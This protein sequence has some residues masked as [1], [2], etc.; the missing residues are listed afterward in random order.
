MEIQSRTPPYF[1][2]IFQ[3][4]TDQDDDML[5]AFG[6]HVHWGYWETAPANTCSAEE[7]AVAAEQLCGLIFDTAGI[8][9]G[10]RILDVGCGFGGAISSLNDRYSD[11]KMVGVNVDQRQL[12]RARQLVQPRSGNSIEFIQAVAEDI[13]MPD[14]GFDT[15]LAVESAFH[16]DRAKFLAEAGRVLNDNGR[17]TVSDFVISEKALDYLKGFDPFDQAGIKNSYGDVDL[18]WSV[19]RYERVAAEHNLEIRQ[20]I[21]ITPN[22]LPTYDFLYAHM[23]SLPEALRDP[24]FLAATRL[25]EKS[26]RKGLMQYLILSFARV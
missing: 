16:F 14:S 5:T 6:R 26:S 10:A 13:P 7:Y 21:D 11:L 20:Q 19:D 9:D 25:L 18:T 2:R 23:E 12:A 4:L 15:V 3:G 17:L 22:T 1:D 24:D 8:R